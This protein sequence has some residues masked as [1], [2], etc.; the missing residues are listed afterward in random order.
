VRGTNLRKNL[1]WTGAGP[2]GGGQ[3]L[4]SLPRAHFYLGTDLCCP[5]Y[6]QRLFFCLGHP[7]DFDDAIILRSG[8]SVKH[9][10]HS[11][12]RTLEAVFKYAL[13]WVSSFSRL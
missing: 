8:V 13:V 1:W 12:H 9:V 2:G 6:H 10:C 4:I 11:I 7:P 5:T 3:K